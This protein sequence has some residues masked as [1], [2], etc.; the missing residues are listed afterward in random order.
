M[1]QAAVGA[2]CTKG[3]PIATGFATALFAFI[4]VSHQ[5]CRG[6][7]CW[8]QIGIFG[9]CFGVVP[10]AARQGGYDGPPKQHQ[11]GGIGVGAVRVVLLAVGQQP[12]G[13]SLLQGDDEPCLPGCWYYLILGCFL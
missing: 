6:A 13:E 4:H 2:G 5:H 9:C 11:G 7:V 3:G 12:Q 10:L 8:S 1:A